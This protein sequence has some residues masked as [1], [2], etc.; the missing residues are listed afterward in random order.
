MIFASPQ[1]QKVLTNMNVNVCEAASLFDLLDTDESGEIEYSA[2]VGGCMRL[3]QAAKA[4]DVIMVMHENREMAKI[5]GDFI[6]RADIGFSKLDVMQSDIKK[7]QRAS[8]VAARASTIKI[9]EKESV[10][11]VP[12][13][14][15]SSG[16]RQSANV[17]VLESAVH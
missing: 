11:K 10:P 4:I 2:F 6:E 5:L 9:I 8:R 17:H 1:M 13:T 12:D 3:R 16:L 14:G 7:Q 15:A